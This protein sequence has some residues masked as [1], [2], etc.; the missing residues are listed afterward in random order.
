MLKPK[1]I[2]S[3]TEVV[4]L[5]FSFLAI[6]IWLLEMADAVDL[7]SVNSSP[8]SDNGIIEIHNDVINVSE[9]KPDL[10]IVKINLWKKSKLT[11]FD[12]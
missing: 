4:P 11:K 2:S 12:F 8:T 5:K 1:L 3:S 6:A 9:V 10:N 7:T